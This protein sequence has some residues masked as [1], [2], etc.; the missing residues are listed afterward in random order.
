MAKGIVD[1]K[2][3]VD[4]K[5]AVKEIRLLGGSMKKATKDQ[6]NWV[7]AGALASLGAKGLNVAIA[8]L[9]RAFMALVG[10]IKDSIFEIGTLGDRIAKQA[11]MIGVT[12]EEFQVLEFAATRSGTSVTAVANGM[13]KLGRVMVDARNGSRQIKDTFEALDI[14]LMKTDGTLRNSF[15]V[16]KDLADKSMILGESAERTGVQMLLLGRSGTELSNLMSQGAKGIEDMKGELIGLGAIMDDTKTAT[17]EEFV[18][19]MADLEFAFRGVKIELGEHLLPEFINLVEAFTDWITTADFSRIKELAQDFFDAAIGVSRFADEVLKLNVFQ[20]SA[21]KVQNDTIN[22]AEEANKRIVEGAAD[23]EDYYRAWKKIPSE[24]EISTGA[25]NQWLQT[26]EYAKLGWKDLLEPVDDAAKNKLPGANAALFLLKEEFQLSA[27]AIAE[28]RIA[29]KDTSA[30]TEEIIARIAEQTELNDTQLMLVGRLVQSSREY[31]AVLDG[32]T[33]AK[34]AN[35]AATEEENR[36]A[37]ERADLIEKNRQLIRRR[38]ANLGLEREAKSRSAAASRELAAAE[39]ELVEIQ[40]YYVSIQGRFAKA[41]EDLYK[42]FHEK[43]RGGISESFMQGLMDEE[44]FRR[45]MASAAEQELINEWARKNAIIMEGLNTGKVQYANNEEALTKLFE[46]TYALRRQNDAAYATGKV[47]MEKE[48]YAIIE[49]LD[50]EKQARQAEI[51]AATLEAS[52]QLFGALAGIAATAA[53]A[54]DKKAAAAAKALFMIQQSFALGSA[55]VSTA[56]SVSTALA[57][58]PGVPYTIPAGILAGVLGAAQIATIVGTTISGVADA[59]LTS[60]VL[61]AAGL[62]QHSAIAVR[63]DETILDPVGTKHIT[64]MLAIQK[65]SMLG[66]NEEQTIRTV[67]ELDGHVL[68]EA[69]DKRLIRQQERGLAYSNNVRQQYEAI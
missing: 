40:K 21:Q 2:I 63:N 38:I 26:T 42:E 61:R 53:A 43:D 32:V 12:A 4:S 8:G 23:L 18:D 46:D 34:G 50:R 47:E 69:V 66:A 33:T 57:T 5:G 13:K 60:D 41:Q 36:I 52:S 51:I 16:F 64:E 45:E 22:N 29:I 28:Y 19:R 39:R 9:K 54:G 30:S 58:F 17:G 67:V 10:P 68:G 37:Q 48:T 11:R 6:T 59:G 31:Q 24:L 20:R 56:Q 62:N 44:S 49:Q 1:F 27:A 15:D 55:I 35:N 14:E 65:A 7:K 25:L 3:K